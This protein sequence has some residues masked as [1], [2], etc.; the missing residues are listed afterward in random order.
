MPCRQIDV[1]AHGLQLLHRLNSK[2]NVVQVGACDGQ[3]GDPVF[4]ILSQGD[5][6]AVLM[7]PVPHSF[8]KLKT[9]YAGVN[10]V[11]PVNAA[12]AEKDGTV[13]IFRVRDAGRWKGSIHAPLWASFDRNHLHKL[14]VHDED[15]EGIEVP[16]LTLKTLIDNHGMTHIDFLLVDAEGYDGK[17]VEMALQLAH[18]PQGICFENVHLTHEDRISVYRRLEENGYRCLHD[19][20]NSLALKDLL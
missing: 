4:E 13:I 10:A 3:A 8:A 7:E 19:S 2:V 1:G 17:V 15:I 12:L 18:Q 16:S 6:R 14:G 9:A 20:M 5:I 11:T